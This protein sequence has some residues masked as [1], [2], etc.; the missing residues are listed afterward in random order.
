MQALTAITIAVERA[1]T[2]EVRLLLLERDAYFDRLYANEDR[3][4]KSV[5]I[6]SR[7]AVF[8]ALRSAGCLVGCGALIRRESYGELKRFFVRDAFRGSGLGR[9]LLET[10]EQHARGNGCRLL[11]LETGILQPAAIAMYRRAG[12]R[13]TGCFGE[14]PPHYL[15]IFM[16]KAL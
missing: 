15:S 10:I 13:E 4:P 9:R 11:R 16:E 2:D 14:Y 3:L 7:D 5:N 1:D 6:E 12:F 8:F